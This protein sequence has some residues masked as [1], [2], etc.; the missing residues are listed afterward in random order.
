MGGGGESVC[1][2]VGKE[3]GDFGFIM[4]CISIIVGNSIFVNISINIRKVF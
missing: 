4:A 1:V 3:V 2:G